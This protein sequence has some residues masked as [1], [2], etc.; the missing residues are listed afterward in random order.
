MGFKPIYFL[1]LY[2]SVHY[3]LLLF[4]DGNPI[5]PTISNIILTIASLITVAILVN[6]FISQNNSNKKFTLLLLVGCIGY[7]IGNAYWTYYEYANG[8]APL[9][10]PYDWLLFIVYGFFLWALIYY[11]KIHKVVLITTY[12]FDILIFTAITATFSWVLIIRPLLMPTSDAYPLGILITNLGHPIA[13]LTILF[14][15]II[16]LLCT[17]L[18]KSILMIILGFF[19]TIIANSISFYE[20]VNN[21]Y[22]L[23]HLID[24]VWGI[25]VI[26]IG[27]SGLHNL[28]KNTVNQR[29]YFKK[30]FQLFI[31][32]TIVIIF[33]F[34]VYLNF[35][36]VKDPL[37]IGVFISIVLLM[38]RLFITI[39]SNEAL[40]IE[41]QQKHMQL[42]AANN[43]LK[44]L[45]Y[46]DELTQLPNRHFLFEKFQNEMIDQNQAHFY[47]LFIDL[48]GFKLV[49]DTF[50]HNAGD[51]LLKQVSQRLKEQ[52]GEGDFL[53]RFA[54]DEFIMLLS[55][56]D[57]NSVE[58]MATAIVDSLSMHYLID[59]HEIAISSSIGISSFEE[60]DSIASVI[61]RADQAM[62][63]IKK[64]GKNGF[65]FI[66]GS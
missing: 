55:H 30:Y 35:Y 10:G 33:L 24:P 46:H 17:S 60:T 34:V 45:A 15:C 5:Q 44:F 19:I 20:I 53:C 25:A 14:A 42:K 32:Y 29:S 64:N 37:L 22:L 41:I 4:L 43:Q 2:I 57:Q 56:R 1:F 65:E 8:I 13:D 39:K 59:S 11:F 26:L 23:G 7:S 27:F 9:I 47:V 40:N 3:G 18:S 36:D 66:S 50:G 28:D 6:S 31:P 52:I 12:I 51:K 16:I 21:T 49:N 38:V 54:G 62:Y 61:N 48:D 58:K 63:N